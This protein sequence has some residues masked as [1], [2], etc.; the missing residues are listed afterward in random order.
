MNHEPF[1]RLYLWCLVC[2]I[3]YAIGRVLFFDWTISD[4]GSAVLWI[5]L[6]VNAFYSAVLVVLYRC[7]APL[8]LHICWQCGRITIYHKDESP[9][10]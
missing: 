4:L 9:P 6:A 5:N 2:T 3:V 8:R 1:A 10:S 7:V